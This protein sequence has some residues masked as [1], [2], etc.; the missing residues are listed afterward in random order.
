MKKALPAVFFVIY[1]DPVDILTGRAPFDK[2]KRQDS[3]IDDRT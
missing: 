2:G 3:F 1:C